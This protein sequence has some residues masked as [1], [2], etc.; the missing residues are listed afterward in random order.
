MER[1]DGTIMTMEEILKMKELL[2]R[3]K[4]IKNQ[5]ADIQHYHHSFGIIRICEPA[6]DRVS[7]ILNERLNDIL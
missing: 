6:V 2:I 3:L 5:L 1:E 4:E 7:K